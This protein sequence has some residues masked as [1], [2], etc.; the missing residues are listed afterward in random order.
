MHSEILAKEIFSWRL[1]PPGAMIV[2]LHLQPTRVDYLIEAT[3]GTVHIGA[4]VC[5][6]PLDVQR[7]IV[8]GWKL[9]VRGFSVLLARD[10][11]AGEA[12]RLG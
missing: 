9:E 1:V 5:P 8:L 10:L 12:L 6:V 4:F 7:H 3:L 2:F 11:G